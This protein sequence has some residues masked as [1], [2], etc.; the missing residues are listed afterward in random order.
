VT[1]KEI[2]LLGMALEALLNNNL[3]DDVKKIVKIM[4]E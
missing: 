1:A 3:L 2:K 4:A